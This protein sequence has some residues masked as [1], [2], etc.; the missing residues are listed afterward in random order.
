VRR[1]A[2]LA[3][4]AASLGAGFPFALDGRWWVVLACGLVGA[5]WLLQSTRDVELRP[6]AIFLFLVGACGAGTFLSYNSVWLLTNLVVTLIAWDL[7]R[8]TREFRLTTKDQPS[9][10]NEQALFRAH[11]KRLGIVVLLGWSLGVVALNVRI[12]LNFGSALILSTL[13]LLS[14]RLVVRFFT[15]HI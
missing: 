13:S 7:D 12:S 11:L 2:Y 14:L 3:I 1:V 4:V 10:K 5:L 15:A 8:F 6:T 9:N